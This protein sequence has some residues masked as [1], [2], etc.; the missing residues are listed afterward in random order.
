MQRTNEATMTNETTVNETGMTD[1][2]V[3]ARLLSAL[4][5]RKHDR[6]VAISEAEFNSAGSMTIESTPIGFQITVEVPAEG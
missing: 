5:A 6:T 3:H 2:E 4:V 1:F